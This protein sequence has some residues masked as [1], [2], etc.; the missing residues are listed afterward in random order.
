MDVNA[1]ARK[2]TNASLRGK[3]VKFCV[4]ED[5]A[6]RRTFPLF[7]LDI[8]KL[9]SY[10][11]WL[12]DHNVS[13]WA[14]VKNYLGAAVGWCAELSGTDCRVE[15]KV[16]EALYARFRQRFQADVPV[17]RKRASKLD[18]KPELMEAMA[19]QTDLYDALSVRDMTAYLLLYLSSIRIGHVAP[20]RLDRSKH[21][22]T[23]GDV[24]ITKVDVF[25]FLHS[26]KTRRAC[27][28]DGWW[29]VMAGRP[30][31]FFALDPVRM[32]SRWR[33][34]SFVC[35]TQPVFHA[36]AAKMLSQTRADFTATL[37]TRLRNACGI[38]PHGHLCKVDRFSGI[39]FRRAGITQLWDKIPQ[40]RLSAHAGH[41]SFSS[42]WAYGGDSIAV[43][44]GNTNEIA[45]GFSSGF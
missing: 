28:D 15:T 25:I 32:F 7:P 21:V 31:G 14:S 42:T 19:L 22:L 1:P 26:T 30:A 27:A 24:I 40:H 20:A 23:W 3:Y 17:K 37:R 43:R 41:A 16:H 39:S 4:D 10:A 44:R 35:D 36:S 33:T 13:G 8:N 5:C 12:P 11:L 29:T 6:E 45:K 9:L 38:L 18:M 34:L 2:A